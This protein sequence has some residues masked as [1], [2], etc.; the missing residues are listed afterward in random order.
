MR[1]I[2]RLTRNVSQSSSSAN[3]NARMSI[4][5]V[6]DSGPRSSHHK[7]S[8]S[9]GPYTQLPLNDGRC[10]ITQTNSSVARATTA[11]RLSLRPWEKRIVGGNDIQNGGG[12]CT[13][14]GGRKMKPTKSLKDTKATVTLATVVLCFAICWIPY[15]TLFTFKPFLAS[16]I[17]CH[18]DLLVLWLG[19][20]NSAINPFLYAFYNSHFRA[21]F[22]RVL[23]PHRYQRAL[24]T[25]IMDEMSW[26]YTSNVDMT[27][28]VNGTPTV[29]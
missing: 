15:F 25:S 29:A 23:C 5:G 24:R 27:E 10:S 6:I 2:N 21:G 26:R 8:C 16:P 28:G 1:A 22:Y 20:A 12:C 4:C 18:V 9:E 3:Q 13:S 11:P 17:N 14:A 7:L 19:Y